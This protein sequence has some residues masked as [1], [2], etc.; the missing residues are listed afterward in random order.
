MV[1][2]CCGWTGLFA[3]PS[4]ASKAS[5]RLTAWRLSRTSDGRKAVKAFKRC[6]FNVLTHSSDDHS[7]NFTSRLNRELIGNSPL[8]STQLATKPREANVSLH[9][10][11]RISAGTRPV[12]LM[13]LARRAGVPIVQAETS[14]E[15]LCQGVNALP[16][17]AKGL[18]IR[19]SRLT[20]LRKALDADRQRV[21]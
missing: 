7:R 19:K 12:H 4:A 14:I 17:S 18:P 15:R 6:V 3:E 16:G 8:P 20:T 10:R 2:G 11:R 21:P 1:G 5:H 13:E 9:S